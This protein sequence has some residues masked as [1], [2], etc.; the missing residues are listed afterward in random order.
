MGIVRTGIMAAEV[1]GASSITMDIEWKI[2]SILSVPSD[3]YYW[4]NI[5]HID[6]SNF[7]I[8]MQDTDEE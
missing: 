4:L 8:S 7:G 3:G 6:A 2:V 1:W 5:S